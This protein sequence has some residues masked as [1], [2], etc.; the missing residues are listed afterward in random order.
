MNSQDARGALQENSKLV[1]VATDSLFDGI[2]SETRYELGDDNFINV[3]NKL[4]RGELAYDGAMGEG[5]D[6]FFVAAQSDLVLKENDPD[7]LEVGKNFLYKLA[8]RLQSK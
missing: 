7:K 6:L 3:C 1:K 2:F 5:L 4:E 8:K